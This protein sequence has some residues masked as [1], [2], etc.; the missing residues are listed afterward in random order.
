MLDSRRWNMPCMSCWLRATSKVRRC[1]W[2]FMA[3]CDKNCQ[4][5]LLKFFLYFFLSKKK[6]AT[7]QN[8]TGF[9]Y[10]FMQRET[11]SGSTH[12]FC[13][14]YVFVFLFFG[15]VS[16][17]ERVP[18]LEPF[19][20]FVFGDDALP[21]F[22][23]GFALVE[24]VERGQ[25][26]HVVL[27]GKRWVRVRFHLDHLQGWELPCCPLCNFRHETARSTPRRPEVHEHGSVVCVDLRG[28]RRFVHLGDYRSRRR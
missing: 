21:L 9:L 27:F 28:P 8:S 16:L 25:S 19:C 26:V 12:V 24:D 17:R 1:V 18:F 2:R 10:L 5:L 11:V 20:E 7:K 4:F 13:W 6:H 14:Y 23:H 3:L 15:A 22:L